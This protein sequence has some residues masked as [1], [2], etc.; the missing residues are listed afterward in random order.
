MKD[1]I[2]D[3]IYEAKQLKKEGFPDFDIAKFVHIELG[4][5]IVYDNNYTENYDK[6]TGEK[7]SKTIQR[8]AMLLE[9]QTDTTLPKQLCKG[10]AE[11]YAGILSELGIDAKV[12][13]AKAKGDITDVPQIYDCSFDEGFNLV[14]GEN[15]RDSQDKAK[16]YYTVFTVD[17]KQYIQDFLIDNA[18]YR[19]KIGE[20]KLNDYTAGICPKEEYTERVSNGLDLAPEYIEMMKDQYAEYIEKH[21]EQAEQ[22]EKTG[23]ESACNFTFEQLKKY[24][25]GFEEAKDYL[26]ETLKLVAQRRNLK[27]GFSVI[28]LVREDEKTCDLCA[29]YNYNGI[30]FA[31][32]S[33]SD[34]IQ[35]RSEKIGVE[36]I[37]FLLTQKF[38]PRKSTDYESLR[39][40][41]DI[42][43]SYEEGRSGLE[44]CMDD[45]KLRS[46]L[47][48]KAIEAA[49]I[50]IRSSATNEISKK[51][52]I[53]EDEQAE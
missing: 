51:D 45:D 25:F 41:V 14:C 26:I 20:T 49:S 2:R 30:N 10:M 47:T 16:H 34:E 23:V 17:G 13:G 40:I 44:D 33:K 19:I 53:D 50:A 3:I 32:L 11:I 38:E 21:K 29:I 15:E 31:L 42:N 48:G 8:Q 12:I 27:E 24:D 6:K 39:K 46:G 35:V 36:E 9:R 4:N 28:N 7:T 18:L 1:E 37:Q 52:E 5:L 22:V 43:M